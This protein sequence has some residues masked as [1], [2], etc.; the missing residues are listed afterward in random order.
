[1]TKSYTDEELHDIY[2]EI[3]P[4][5]L[6]VPLGAQG[7]TPNAGPAVRVFLRYSDVVPG[8]NG[9]EQRYWEAL[10]RTPVIA[11]IGVLSIVNGILSSE[12]GL[13]PETHRM[14][15][16]RL[17]PPDLRRRVADYQPGGPAL[18]VVFNRVGCL[19]LMRHL[20]IYGNQAIS[21]A[22]QAME[23]LG[24]LA[25]LS[26]EFIQADPRPMTSEPS[27]LDLLLQTISSWDVYNPSDLAY[28]L[29]RIFVFLTKILPGEDAVVRKL[30]SRVGIDPSQITIGD[31]SL[32][33]FIAT[34][35]GLYAYGRKMAISDPR[36]A[37]VNRQKVFEKVKFSLPVL[38]KFLEN[39]SLTIS[40]FAERL[41]GGLGTRES[42]TD[43]LRRRPFLTDSLN[44]FR[45][46][47]L[48]RLDEDQALILDLQFLVELLTSGVYWKIYNSLPASR[49]QPFRELWGRLFELYTVNLLGEFYPPA[50]RM[51]T[52]DV[53]FPNGQ[54]D[55][56]LEFGPDVFVFEMKASLLTEPAKRLGDRAEFVKDF[57]LKFVRNERGKPKAVVQLMT[58]CKAI[59]QGTIPTAARPTR[60][61][62]V[63][64][65]DEP[66][67][68]AFCFNAYLNEIFQNEL[69]P[70]PVVQPI[71]SMSVKEFE[72]VL[73]CVSQGAFSWGDLL[74]SRFNNNGVGPFSVHQAIYNLVQKNKIQLQRSQIIRKAFDE[75][76]SVISSKYN[77]QK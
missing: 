73:T 36:C 21:D 53:R 52:P 74:A 68:E 29:T 1:M 58:S 7:R 44:V 37:I 61:Y 55:A 25:L 9:L 50:S 26:N 40:Q 77:A 13:D 28:S 32:S 62:P 17:L 46:Y 30:S 63:L 6:W 20:M 31:L 70:S 8:A 48:L 60:I 69:G 11:A 67:V 39:R 76:C 22:G 33:D 43:E 2:W 38:S 41:S 16:E 14:L 64:V 57:N 5:R 35:F 12:G 66:I 18:P 15:N 45:Q 3:V 72:E 10:Q 24:E 75:V 34:V 42:F 47:P 59:E 71:T 4:E 51:L 49:R 23:A 54:I 19:Q 27:N 65:C 56:L